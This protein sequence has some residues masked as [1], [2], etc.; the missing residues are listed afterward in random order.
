MGIEHSDRCLPP[1]L[2]GFDFHKSYS[3]RSFNSVVL[4]KIKHQIQLQNHTF[5]NYHSLKKKKKYG[6]KENVLT[7][8]VPQ[9]LKSLKRNYISNHTVTLLSGGIF[10]FSSVL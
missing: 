5:F 6:V 2:L 8:I 7:S 3:E 10:S 1:L 4:N 9:S